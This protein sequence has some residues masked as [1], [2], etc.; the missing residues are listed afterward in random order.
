MKTQTVRVAA[1][2]QDFSFAAGEKI[3]MEI[4]QKYSREQIKELA[5]NAGFQITGEYF[6]SRHY[7]T[8]Q[9]WLMG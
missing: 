6:D 4:S 2:D 5:A 1:L 8:D 9:I 3:F 7:F